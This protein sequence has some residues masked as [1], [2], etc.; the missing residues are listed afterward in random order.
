MHGG[1]ISTKLDR[2]HNTP[3]IDQIKMK[4]I[5]L[6]DDIKIKT[7]TSLNENKIIKDKNQSSDYL[8]KY[9]KGIIK[10]YIYLN[11][12]RGESMDD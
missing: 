10:N 5:D 6:I 3:D 7:N 11:E 8:I 9:F 2:L 1:N 12:Y 4:N